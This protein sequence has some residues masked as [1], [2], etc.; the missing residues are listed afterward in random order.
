MLLLAKEFI[1]KVL[2][3]PDINKDLKCEGS[4][5]ITCVVQLDLTGFH[6]SMKKVPIWR[7]QKFSSTVYCR[8]LR[9]AYKKES[10]ES[11]VEEDQ[12]IK[13][14]ME[15]LST[16]DPQI[17]GNFNLGNIGNEKAH[18]RELPLPG[19]SFEIFFFLSKT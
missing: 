18:S 15:G 7:N 3:E 5:F 2:L 13:S 16:S 14:E 17:P 4:L 12:H 9:F 8:S 19:M 11:V 6:N 1:K 10:K